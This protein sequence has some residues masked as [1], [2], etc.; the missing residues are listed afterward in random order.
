MI[1]KIVFTVVLFSLFL[2]PCFHASAQDSGDSSTISPIF[3]MTDFPQWT[4]DLRR[5]EIVAFGTFPFSMFFVTFFHDM[6]RWNNA[7]GMDF[8]EYGRRYAPWP[9][10]SAGSVDMTGEEYMKTFLFAAGLSVVIAFVDLI[11]VKIRQSMEN[12]RVESV[13]SSSVN[14]N[15]RP[16]ETDEEPPGTD[17][18]NNTDD[19]VE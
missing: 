9:F 14:V 13:P 3:D 15:R 12:R 8:S 5:W 17:G 4:K 10:K 7:N 6:Y 1:K 16:V 19:T 2:I 18:T 11:I